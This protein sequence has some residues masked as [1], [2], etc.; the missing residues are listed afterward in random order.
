MKN[1]SDYYKVPR[2]GTLEDINPFDLVGTEPDCRGLYERNNFYYLLTNEV[3]QG[4]YWIIQLNYCDR[5]PENRMI[6]ILK[7]RK[8][9]QR[10]LEKNA[11]VIAIPIGYEKEDTEALELAQLEYKKI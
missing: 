5:E 11:Q 2:T 10:K 6:G 1:K 8:L 7:K 3:E 4:L 9:E